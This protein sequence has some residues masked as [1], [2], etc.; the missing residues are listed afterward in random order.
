LSHRI[1][2]NEDKLGRD[3][4]VADESEGIIPRSVRYLWQQMSQRQESFYVK[5]SFM[6][7]YNEQLNDL[8]DP[9]SGNLHYRWNVQNVL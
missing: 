6:E 4:Y 9:S 2:G 8:L 7:I 1:A 3:V 5:A